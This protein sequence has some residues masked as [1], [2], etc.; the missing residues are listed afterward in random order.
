MK[1]GI[2]YYAL[3]EKAEGTG[4]SSAFS[5]YCDATDNCAGDIIADL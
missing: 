3:F 5:Q 1:R 4:D 2:V